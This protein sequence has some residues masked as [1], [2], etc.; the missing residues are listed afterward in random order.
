MNI[1]IEVKAAVKGMTVEQYLSTQGYDG[2]VAVLIAEG[3]IITLKYGNPYLQRFQEEYKWDGNGDFT[4]E[5]DDE[6]PFMMMIAD[7]SDDD[8]YG[9]DMTPFLKEFNFFSDH[10]KES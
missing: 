9:D 7:N 5:M 10:F 2:Y 8:I 3:V 6:D 1:K 4:I